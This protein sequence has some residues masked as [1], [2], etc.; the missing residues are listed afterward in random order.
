MISKSPEKSISIPIRKSQFSFQSIELI[1]TD[2]KQTKVSVSLPGYLF[3]FEIIL[4][5]RKLFSYSE[6]QTAF[7]EKH[8]IV[9]YISEIEQERTFPKRSSLWKLK[10]YT[11]IPELA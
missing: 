7:V 6:F 8:G 5:V 4:T 2:K 3:T 1:S 10:I 9:P 11:F